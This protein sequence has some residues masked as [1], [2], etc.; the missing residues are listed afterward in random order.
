MKPRKSLGQN[1]LID[2]NIQAKIIRACDLSGNDTILEIGPGRGEITQHLLARAGKV[3]AVEIDRILY[4]GLKEKF[5]SFKNLELLNADILKLS[6]SGLCGL[7][8]GKEL[9]VIANIPYY[10]SSPI[11]TYLLSYGR[12]FGE[13]YLTLQKE[14]AERLTACPGNKGY[15]SF[16][17]FAQFYTKPKLLFTIPSSAFWP[18]PKVDSCLAR[19]EVLDEPSVKVRKKELFFKII[20]AG[21][22]QRRKLFKNNLSRLFPHPQAASCLNKLGLDEKV[23]AEDLSLSDFAKIADYF[24]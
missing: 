15:G 24:T 20:R 1:F 21:F 17:C 12:L 14:F 11:I 3:I 2:K 9:K 5:G 22:N 7:R 10:I 6:L 23:R 16:S 8:G 18:R 19:L 4:Q 13:I